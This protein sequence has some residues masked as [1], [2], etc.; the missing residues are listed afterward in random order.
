M[1]GEASPY[2]EMRKDVYK[3]SP[4]SVGAQYNPQGTDEMYSAL[5]NKGGGYNLGYNK[6]PVNVSYT[7]NPGLGNN[8]MLRG[9]YNFADG[10]VASMF[11]ERPGY[12][13]G[14]TIDP[15]LALQRSPI[16]QYGYSDPV[17]SALTGNI[18]TSGQ[19]FRD[20]F[21]PQAGL[22]MQHFVG[23]VILSL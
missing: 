22:M 17:I 9:Q 4:Y 1:T 10:G 12:Q 7:S 13:V 14:G 18:F 6:G 23:G 11:R 20:V 5:Y 15:M 3:D 19:R 21:S 16:D 8:V 2:S